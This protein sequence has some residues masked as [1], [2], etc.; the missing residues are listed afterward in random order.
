[1]NPEQRALKELVE[2]VTLGGRKA[3]SR[4][5]AETVMEWADEVKYPGFRAGPED[6]ASPSNWTANPVP[7]IHL[8][9]AGRGT[10]VPVAPGVTPRTP[11][12]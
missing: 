4:T 6:L 7:H 9:G 8:P 11:N 10:H 5:E 1:M 2:E 12:G 3:L